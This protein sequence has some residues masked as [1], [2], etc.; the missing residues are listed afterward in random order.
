ME[1]TGSTGHSYSLS[2]AG[3]GPLATQEGETA[4]DLF[5]VAAN[6]DLEFCENE[7]SES[8][9]LPISVTDHQ[10][11]TVF[12]KPVQKVPFMC[13]L[14]DK[15]FDSK[16]KSNKHAML[17]H[18]R[19][20]KH[21]HL[22]SVLLLRNTDLT[23]NQSAGDDKHS[24][25]TAQ[26]KTKLSKKKLSR[27]LRSVCE[28]C[29]W[30]SNRFKTL[31]AHMQT[32]SEERSPELA[33][34]V[35]GDRP[36]CDICGWVC[37]TAKKHTSLPFK[38]HMRKHTA[39]TEE[40][41][42]EHSASV[43][44]DKT[45]KADRPVCDICGW[46]CKKAKT[47]TSL[48]FREH[49]RKHSGEKPF[50]CGQC[51]RTFRYKPNLQRHTNVSHTGER[52]FLCQYCACSYLQY[53]SL[54]S[55]IMKHHHDKVDS[56]TS[57]HRVT[58]CTDAGAVQAKLKSAL[59]ETCGKTYSSSSALQIHKCFD[60]VLGT[61]R[62]EPLQHVFGCGLC[63]MPYTSAA[64]LNRHVLSHGAHSSGSVYKCQLCGEQFEQIAA[65][66]DHL[67]VVHCIVLPQYQCSECY[68]S[69]SAESVLKLHM[70]VH[71]D[72]PHAFECTVCGKKFIFHSLLKNHMAVHTGKKHVFCAQANNSTTNNDSSMVLAAGGAVASKRFICSMC[73]KCFGSRQR[74]DIHKR[75]HSGEKPFRCHLCSKSFNQRAHLIRHL[76]AHNKVKP[77]HCTI[78]TKAYSSRLDLR[79]HCSHVHNIQLPVRHHTAS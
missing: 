64:R 73:G 31:E 67:T 70:R 22:K 37:K 65:L 59:C 75:V 4:S 12:P 72:R 3:K 74:L 76:N 55:H 23:R 27:D 30:I 44:K 7:D 24:T 11:S 38:A 40:K 35:P 77:Y 36:M 45:S 52:R 56:N 9:S 48:T 18:G 39:K 21:P 41:L 78:C 62:R 17:V 13:H 43:F 63:N 29:G 68:A 26:V 47:S 33:T 8:A 61:H 50:A 19:K 71:S 34:T 53:E 69:F 14:C 6:D 46:V 57:T 49:M 16:Y 28:V 2:D 10:Y 5:S 1:H 60:A 66:R 32:H 25:T 20:R 51:S 15:M 58:K 54:L 79:L 42:L